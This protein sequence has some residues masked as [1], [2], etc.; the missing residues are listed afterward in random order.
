MPEELVIILKP[1]DT[2]GGQV[3]LGLAELFLPGGAVDPGILLGHDARE[4]TAVADEHRGDMAVGGH[5][6]QLWKTLTRLGRGHL[7][8]VV[9]QRHCGLAHAPNVRHVRNVPSPG[10]ARVSTLSSH[11]GTSP[12]PRDSTPRPGGPRPP[13][14][15][16]VQVIAL[17]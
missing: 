14:G 11:A 9:R 5:V 13:R 4:P 8:D 10:T 7:L 6:D 15:R 16:V 1:L 3:R 2:P 12:G 17:R